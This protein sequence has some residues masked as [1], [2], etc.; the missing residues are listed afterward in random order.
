MDLIDGKWFLEIKEVRLH[1][2]L[3]PTPSTHGGSNRGAGEQRF[4]RP[5]ACRP[6]VTRAECPRTPAEPPP[7]SYA[8]PKVRTE[9]G[10]LPVQ[11]RPGQGWLTPGRRGR[12]LLAGGISDPAVGGYRT[13]WEAGRAGKTPLPRDLE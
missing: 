3:A 4:R 9:E 10:C 11:V 13:G 8:G 5:P 2:L 12:V 6:A 1:G 7:G